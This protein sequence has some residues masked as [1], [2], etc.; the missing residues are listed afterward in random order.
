M[1]STSLASVIVV[2]SLSA[3]YAFASEGVTFNYTLSGKDWPG[4]C[5]VGRRQSPINIVTSEVVEKIIS[6]AFK[7]RYVSSNAFT[8]KNNG[9]VIEVT[10]SNAGH[11]K[12]ILRDGS[13][14]TLRQFHFHGFSEHSFDGF[15][16]PLEVHFVH[17]SDT[18]PGK[19]AVVGCLLAV[20]PD[21]T[22]NIYLTDI[23]NNMPYT[24]SSTNVTG[25]SVVWS[26]LVLSTPLYRV[27]TYLGSLTTPTCDE[28]VEWFLLAKPQYIST[29]QA[30]KFYDAVA[31]VSNGNRM[32]NRPTQATNGRKVEAF[33]ASK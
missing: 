32:N 27:Y 2:L 26:D 13:S 28:V 16:S 8:V 20:H 18:D 4:S 11:N 14:Y 6:F 24:I 31:A 29:A 15:F 23:I 21:E 10:P 22:D 9:H 3:S 33:L 1:A 19:I 17:I 7:L 12:L 30:I 5:P 25:S